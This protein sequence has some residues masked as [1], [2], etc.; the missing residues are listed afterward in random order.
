MLETLIFDKKAQIPI[1]LQISDSI[2]YQIE[3]GA[4]T[5]GTIAIYQ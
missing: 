1:Y 4:L 3:K 2:M 5:N